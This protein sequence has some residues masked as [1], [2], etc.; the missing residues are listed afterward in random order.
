MKKAREKVIQERSVHMLLKKGVYTEQTRN[1]ICLL[2]QAGCSREYVGDVI[3]AIFKAAR[4]SV[5]GHVSRCTVSQAV[6]EG[7]Y[8]AQIQLGYE[9]QN[10]EGMTFSADGTTHRAINYTSWHVNL[11]AESYKSNSQGTGTE[12]ATHL[13]GVYSA[14]DG[15]ST[16]SVKAW[17][18]LLGNIADIY[19]QSP[20]GKHAGHLLRVV[21]IFV[22]L[23]GMHTDHC[24]KEKKDVKLLEKEKML[25]TYQSLGEDQIVEKSKQE[26][27]PYFFEAQKKMINLAGGKKKWDMLS[28]EQKA[29]RHAVSMEQLTKDL[30]KNHYD[31]LLDDEKRILKLFIWAGCGYHKDLNTVHGG[32]AAMMAWWEKNGVE[33]PVLLANRDN[34]AVLK[35]KSPTDDVATPAQE[36]AFQMTTHGGVKTAQI[37]GEIFNN[38]NDKKGHHDAFQWWWMSNVKQA[39]TFPGTSNNCFQ[40]HCEAAAL[41]QHKPQFI[42]FLEYIKEKKQTMRFSHMEENLWKALHCTATLTELAVL[43]L[44]AQAVT[45]P[46]MKNVRVSGA[47][48]VNMLDLG[49]LHQKVY[50]HIQRIIGDPSFLV[51]DSVTW[52]TGAMDGQMWQTP[53]AVA[54]VQKIAPSL[55]HLREVLVAF[56]EGAAVTWKHFTSEFAPGG[57]IDEATTEEKELAWMPPTNDANEGALGSFRV[58]MHNQP[59]LTSLQYNAQAMYAHNNTQAFMEKKFQPEDYKYIHQLAHKDEAKGVERA[60][61][62]AIVGHLQH[63]I[64]KKRAARAAR[65]GKAAKVAGRVAAVKLIF[66]K[67]QVRK[68]KGEKLKD[69]LQAFQR[70][71]A[72]NLQNMSL[73]TPVV[74]IREG[75]MQSI[76]LFSTGQ[77]KPNTNVGLETIPMESESGEEFDLDEGEDDWEEVDE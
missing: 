44:Y 28:E 60:K 75:L 70:A 54:A 52:E 51:G 45:H 3:Q 5:V 16:E 73:R 49:P 61:K 69:H 12:Q 77:W 56:F 65:L 76:D 22:K 33:P 11:K 68:L 37:A 41:I 53:E 57:L 32:N 36:R 71:G 74:K 29:E 2:V 48:K 66:D 42:R 30:G 8:A 21:D 4:I 38:K 6:V 72:P 26:L 58:L 40:S 17:K 14:L 9:M 31:Q 46:Y 23:V 50:R 25:A 64:D 59:H 20:L 35:D 43:A 39:F 13:I 19:N 27:L 47:V 67:E 55:P 10:A 15:S 7:Y 1:L 63:K 34:A 18:D 62:Q 24:A